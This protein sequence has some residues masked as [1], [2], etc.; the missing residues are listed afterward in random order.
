[1][2]MMFTKHCLV[3]CKRALDRCFTFELGN[4]KLESGA[5]GFCY[6]ICGNQFENE[7]VHTNCALNDELWMKTFVFPFAP[8]VRVRQMQW[9]LHLWFM[10]MAA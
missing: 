9:F 8:C 5:N 4:F 1:M 7:S 2:D 3:A 6:R 10:L